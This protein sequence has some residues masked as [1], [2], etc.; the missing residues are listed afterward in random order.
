MCIKA[1][2]L[3]CQKKNNVATALTKIILVLLLHIQ[4]ITS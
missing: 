3:L 2:E 4:I 1:S